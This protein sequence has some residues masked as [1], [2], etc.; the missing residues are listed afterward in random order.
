MG[1]N[2]VNLEESLPTTRL[3]GPLN[4]TNNGTSTKSLWFSSTVESGKDS[5]SKSVFDA[6]VIRHVYNMLG[7]SKVLLFTSLVKKGCGFLIF[8]KKLCIKTPGTI[9][10]YHNTQDNFWAYE[11]HSHSNTYIDTFTHTHRHTHTPIYIHT[12]V[13]TH[14]H[15]TINKVVT[16]TPSGDKLPN[17]SVNMSANKDY[18]SPRTPFSS[19]ANQ[20]L[21]VEPG[22]STERDTSLNFWLE[23]AGGQHL[24]HLFLC[25][26]P[27]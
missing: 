5:R 3:R 4:M 6:G 16:K 26:M 22:T 15:T 7:E 8:K 14:T 2:P 25:W 1:E 21:V 17:F 13:Q 20:A 24:A 12:L 10:I 18:H 9:W 19:S 23:K 11:T 27:S